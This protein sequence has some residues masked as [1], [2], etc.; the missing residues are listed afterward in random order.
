MSPNVVPFL[1]MKLK[2][3][4]LRVWAKWPW[5]AVG[6]FFAVAGIVGIT[7]LV[8][9]PLPEMQKPAQSSK[10]LAADGQVIATLHGEENRTIVP[11]EEISSLLQVA[12]VSEEDKDFFEHRGMSVKAIVRAARANLKGGEIQQGGSTITQQLVRNTMPD[13]GTDRTYMRKI[14]EVFWAMRLE[15]EMYKPEIMERYLNTVYFGRGA[16]GAEAAARTYF[17]L[18]ASELT[19]GQAAYLAGVIRSPE[20]YQIDATRRAPSLSATG[21]ST[22]MEVRRLPRTGGGCGGQGRGPHRPVQAGHDHRGRL[23]PGGL[24]RRVRT[25]HPHRDFGLNDEEILA[26]GLQIHTTLDL[27]AQDAA[28]AAVRTTLGPSR[29]PRGRHG[30]DGQRGP[31]PGDGRRA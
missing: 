20:R 27:K 22:G 28:E 23:A 24:L 15:R 4:L 8:T 19:A 11:L 17:K 26:G 14:K 29:R 25:P 31:D 13:I 10:M 18:S 12:L 7:R 3:A 30:G 16:Y 6:A 1:N 5:M 21:F 2:N 9:L